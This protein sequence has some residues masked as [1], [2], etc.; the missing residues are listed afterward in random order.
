[1]CLRMSN[2]PE[3][4]FRQTTYDDDIPKHLQGNSE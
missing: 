3:S 4:Y 1:M 2:I